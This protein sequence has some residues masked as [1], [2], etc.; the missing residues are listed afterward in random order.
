MKATDF[1]LRVLTTKLPANLPASRQSH[2][3]VQVVSLR[4]YTYV[5]VRTL[6]NTSEVYWNRFKGNLDFG[7]QTWARLGDANNHLD[8]DPCV[9]VNTFLGRIEVFGVF[10]SGHVMHTWQDGP[11]GFHGNWEKL[12]GLFSPKFSSVPVVYQ[13]G[14]SD[15][16]GILNL[17]VRGEDGIMHHISQTT[18]D[19]VNNVWGPC[20]WGTFHKVGGQPPSDGDMTN[21]FTAINSIHRGIEVCGYSLSNFSVYLC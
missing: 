6:T 7:N 4:N 21:P 12:G 1:D 20:T 17:F 11:D 3:P 14:H 5:F 9:G 19:K 13:M 10:Q 16:N 2:D 18:C 15:F 8:F